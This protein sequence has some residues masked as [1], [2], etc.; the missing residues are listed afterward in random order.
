[1][2]AAVRACPGQQLPRVERAALEARRELLG[3]V[4]A[5]VDLGRLSRALVQL[6]GDDVLLA[7]VV[8]AERRS[9]PA[10]S[11][12]EA[13]V[14]QFP[15]LGL[16]VAL[17]PEPDLTRACVARLLG[18]GFELGWADTGIDAALRG[19]GGSFTFTTDLRPDRGIDT[20]MF[21]ACLLT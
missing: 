14:I 18:Q 15:G 7:D 13:H 19:A 9:A 4:A 2:S 17:W 3:R 10:P 1:M 8:L 20:K 5:S 12:V 11:I 6:L 16:R 21:Q